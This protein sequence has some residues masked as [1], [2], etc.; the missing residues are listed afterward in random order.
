MK[1][2]VTMLAFV[3]AALPALAGTD[4]DLRLVYT[5]GS[6]GEIEPCG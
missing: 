6:A 3:F 2:L 5:S 4:F 1:R